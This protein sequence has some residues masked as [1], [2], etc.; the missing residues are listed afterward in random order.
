MESWSRQY[1]GLLLFENVYVQRQVG[2]CV[3]VTTA[4]MARGAL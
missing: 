3:C 2:D 1:R 4:V